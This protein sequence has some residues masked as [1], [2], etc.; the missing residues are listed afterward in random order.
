MGSPLTQRVVRRS[1][2]A[3]VTQPFPASAALRVDPFPVPGKLH[4]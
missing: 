1:R 2:G 4:G 3:R